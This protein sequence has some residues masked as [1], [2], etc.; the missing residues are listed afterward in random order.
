LNRLSRMNSSSAEFM[1]VLTYL[2]WLITLPWNEGTQDNLNVRYA[3]KILDQDHH[4]LKKPKQRI[5]EHLAVRKLKPESRGPIL[6]FAGPPGTGKT[7]L[8][9]SIARAMGRNFVKMSL[10]GVRDEAEIRGH[11]RTYVGALPG[12]IIQGLRRAG[13]NNPVF[14]LDEIDKAGQSY[15]GDP[16]SALLEVLDP[17]QNHSFSD[18]YLDVAFD[19]SNVMF[20]TTANFLYPIPA[21]L[22]DR[23]EVI[24]LPGYSLDEKAKIA[25]DYLIPRQL[26]GHGI[27][28]EQL[29]F[30]IGAIRLVI[31]GYTREPGVRNL[32][33][34]IAA[35]CRAV[36]SRIANGEIQKSTI[37]VKNLSLY[38]GPPKFTSPLPVKT[39][40]PGIAIGLAGTGT[41]GE[42]ITV[43]AFSMKG[44]HGL[45][46]TGNLGEVMRESAITALSYVRS[47]TVKLGI[48]E[49]YYDS[50]DIH[51]HIPTGSMEKEGTGT[52][53][54]ILIAFV[55]LLTGR[56]SK[57]HL[58][59]A[60][61]ISLR[62]QVLPVE[63][64]TDIVLAA[65]RS[66][67]KTIILP[68]ENEKDLVEIP[69]KVRKDISFNFVSRMS[70]AI[71]I[72]LNKK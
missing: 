28:K 51:V 43:E 22:R 34:E 56:L 41:G 72:A 1:V 37:S 25:K 13:S 20:I 15:G 19:L 23:M 58:A 21:A 62:G 65:H 55:S 9:R 50:H 61:E 26:E 38:L 45:I 69:Q 35:V 11:R 2:D 40:V 14:M 60:G 29:S 12:R 30:T 8:G 3:Q 52:G 48:D 18:H 67:I 4:G 53:L 47:N 33:R 70:D 44:N 57:K 32:E 42:I 39:M 27:K 7:S 24:E 36:A 16:S 59:V 10:G 66:N 64:V 5:I 63:S 71:K 6:C 49:N 46:L 54:P 68:K 17:E 31:S